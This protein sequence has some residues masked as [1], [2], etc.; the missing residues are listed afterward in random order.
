MNQVFSRTIGARIL[1]L[2]CENPCFVK[3]TS[4][5]GTT[6]LL[7]NCFVYKLFRMGYDGHCDEVSTVVV[8]ADE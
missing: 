1:I 3:Y 5:P 8:S 7:M 4:V 6:D 2:L